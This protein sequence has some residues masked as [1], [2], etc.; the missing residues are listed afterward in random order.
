MRHI[1]IQINQLDRLNEF[2]LIITT[3]F[4]NGLHDLNIKSSLI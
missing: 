3:R 1:T 4:I 2:L